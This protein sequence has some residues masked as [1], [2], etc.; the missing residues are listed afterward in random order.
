ME[1]PTRVVG[2]SGQDC[3]NS[4]EDLSKL[5]KSLV[6]EHSHDGREKRTSIRHGFSTEVTVQ[7]ADANHGPVGNAYNAV[8]RDIS[9]SGLRLISLNFVNTPFLILEIPLA[10]GTAKRLLLKVLRC[11]P[12]RR[13]F[14]VGGQFETNC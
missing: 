9:G 7:P 1:T 10:E 14:E 3:V 6:N 13:Y 12:F 8:T 5:V 2:W 11:R 4:S